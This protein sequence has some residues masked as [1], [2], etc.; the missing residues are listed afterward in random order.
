MRK[1]PNFDRL[2]DYQIW[3]SDPSKVLKMGVQNSLSSFPAKKMKK[4][5]KKDKKIVVVI[6]DI[7]NGKL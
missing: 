5:E 1:S 7:S 3:I 6:E 2:V 4:S